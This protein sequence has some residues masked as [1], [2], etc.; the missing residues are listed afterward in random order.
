ML[1]EDVEAELARNLPQ[2][3]LLSGPDTA[4]LYRIVRSVVKQHSLHQA[5]LIVAGKVTAADAR[6]LAG[7]AG[8]APWGLFKVL[9]L[10]L[11]HA[12]RD[13]QNILLRTLEEPPGNT[14]FILI[15]SQ[16]VPA[17]IAG[18]CRRYEVTSSEPA[19]IRAVDDNAAAAVD[20][21]VRAALTRDPAVLA[22]ALRP[23]GERCG[24]SVPAKPHDKGEH[25][26]PALQAWA[27]ACAVSLRPELFRPEVTPPGVPAPARCTRTV[28]SVLSRYP[29]ARPQNAAAAALSL[30]FLED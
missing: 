30:A 19:T 10:M 7:A 22:E 8:T 9:I 2:A 16:P 4:E 26:L 11:D 12:S 23:W 21:A 13:A 14:R 1:A 27:Q 6:V 25:Y 28:L 5:D 17:A 3:T 15:T 24:C 29:R 18:R 20:A